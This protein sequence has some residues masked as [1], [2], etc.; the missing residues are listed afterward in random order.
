MRREYDLNVPT[1][2]GYLAPALPIC[3]YQVLCK[4]GIFMCI[5]YAAVADRRI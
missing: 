1:N 3:Y 2:S 5:L 4:Y